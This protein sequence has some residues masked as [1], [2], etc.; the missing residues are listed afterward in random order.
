MFKENKLQFQLKMVYQIFGTKKN[1][2]LIS[3]IECTW[4]SAKI[5]NFVVFKKRIQNFTVVDKKIQP[6]LIII[7]S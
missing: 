6:T 2:L 3:N 1:A 4:P 5:A 7:I